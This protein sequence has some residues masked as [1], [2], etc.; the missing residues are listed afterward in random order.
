MQSRKKIK[1]QNQI[2]SPE[3]DPV[4]KG[5]EADFL[6][7]ISAFRK[8]Q[9]ESDALLEGVRAV[10]ESLNFHDAAASIFQSC[11]KII[12]AEAG[13]IALVSE[14]GEQNEI[15]YLDGGNL[16]CNVDP[17]HPMPIRGLRGVVCKSGKP[18]YENDFQN[19]EFNRFIPEGHAALTNVLMA[20]LCIRGKVVGLL[21]LA[22]KQNGFTDDDLRIASAF[23]ELTAIA[24]VN[25]KT[26]EFLKNAHDEMEKRIGERTEELITTN[27]ALVESE[28]KY[29]MLVEQ[30]SDGIFILDREGKINEV[31]STACQMLGYTRDEIIRLLVHD[32]IP[33]EDLKLTPLKIEEVMAGD[34][35]VIQ[36]RFRRKNG[37][38]LSVEVSAKKID[39]ERLQTIVRDLTDRKKAEEA[40]RL[41]DERLA[42]A[43]KIARL[44]N[45]DWNILTNE[46]YWSSEVYHIFSLSQKQV[47]PTY[48][49]FL[50]SIHSDDREF[51]K[52]SV[53]EALYGAPYGIDHRIVHPDGKVRYVHEQGKVTF[54]ESGEPVRMIGTVQDITERKEAEKALQDS[55]AKYQAIVEGFDGF[56]Y[57]CS[58]YNSIEFMNDLLMEKV[59]YNAVGEKCYKALYGFENICPWC[60]HQ[61]RITE[62]IVRGEMNNPDNNR[63]YYVVSTPIQNQDGTK[64]N[65]MM[66]QDIT[67][68]KN[69]ELRLIQSEKLAALGQMASGIAHE[70]NNPLATISACT[71]GLLNR[72]KK[73][74]I[75]KDLFENYLQIINEEVVRS[76]GITTNML[77]FVRKTG[78]EKNDIDINEV[79]ER[80]LE[81]IGFQG[82]LKNVEVVRNYSGR[83]LVRVNEGEI[84]Q[85]LLSLVVNALDAMDDKGTLILETGKENQAVFIK[86]TDTGPG[87]PTEF[88]SKIFDPFFTTRSGRGGTGLGL[89]IAK[90]IIDDSHGSLD[91]L[92]QQGRGVTF[93]IILP[94]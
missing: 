30:A 80:T 19:T 11:K 2:V 76:K 84:R 94:L 3:M 27:K 10:L 53:S 68:K 62:K 75:E 69:N 21:G 29:R 58:E 4:K 24:L 74:N 7:A 86:I 40:L 91:V 37:S 92:T 1:T 23:G 50:N 52:K 34:K 64:S 73:G 63:W 60:Q 83:L 36:R 15:T 25:K 65:M 43:Q 54:G 93:K 35:V 32:L 46:L 67:D 85:V 20:P 41:S 6:Q 55:K 33:K 13:Y 22:N 51:V 56:I 90:K 17:D 8:Q 39:Q 47:A 9:Q 82:R 48:D 31:N 44:G 81:L 42:E 16:P 79:L 5:S 12:R 88:V 28:R 38:L 77:S 72:L 26:E 18:S 70:I 89:S 78:S 61:R 66:L 57:I 87:I 45:W 14:D 49:M 59:G 71:E